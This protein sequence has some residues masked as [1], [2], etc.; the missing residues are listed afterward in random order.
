MKNKN[1]K[2]Q[3]RE[4]YDIDQQRQPS[5]LVTSPKRKPFTYITHHVVSELLK[6]GARAPPHHRGRQPKGAVVVGFA[7]R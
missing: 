2:H 5:V 4:K 6:I 3:Q 7:L 1:I